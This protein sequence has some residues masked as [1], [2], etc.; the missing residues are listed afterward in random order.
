MG[1]KCTKCHVEKPVSEFNKD[2][3][4]K[5]GI[6]AYCKTCQS[7]ERRSPVNK[8]KQVLSISRYKIRQTGAAV[9]DTLTSHGVAMVLSEGSCVYC[10]H[11]LTYTESTVDH[12]IPFSRGGANS[13]QNVVSACKSCNS[14]KAD[15]PA[16]LHMIQH[17]EPYATKKLLERLALRR[18]V[19]TEEIYAELVLDAQSYFAEQ[20]AQAVAST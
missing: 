16:L 12:V 17:C 15:K 7:A 5:S 19:S 10:Q 2:R 9:E 20:S 3:R 14:S 13:F 1:K 8:A 4:I 11:P 18:G 6:R